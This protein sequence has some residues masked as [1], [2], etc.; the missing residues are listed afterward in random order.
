MTEVM[1]YKSVEY[2]VAQTVH[3]WKWTLF[4]TPTRTRTGLANSR[5]DAVSDAERAIDQLEK[6][7]ETTR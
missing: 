7:P 6:N 2:R 3:G 4:L 5:S 1:E